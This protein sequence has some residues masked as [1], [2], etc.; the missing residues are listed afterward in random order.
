MLE[1]MIPL[2]QHG[3]T[4]TRHSVLFA[5]SNLTHHGG[6]EARRSI[7]M[8]TTP[9]IVELLAAPDC[10]T[11]IAE[12]GL[13]VL[14]HSLSSTVSEEI[15]DYT[16]GD[17]IH[18]PT[19]LRNI[20]AEGLL[21]AIGLIIRRPDVDVEAISH[22]LD[23]LRS[24]A[25]VYRNPMLATNTH[26]PLIAALASP[27]IHVRLEG[28]SG[29]LRLGG[30]AV[31][32]ESRLLN[33]MQVAQIAENPEKYFNPTLMKALR[34]Q[35]GGW[36]GGMIMEIAESAG[37]LDVEIQQLG[38][39]GDYAKLGRAL[40]KRILEH[41]YSLGHGVIMGPGGIEE[42]FDE[43]FQRAGDALRIT[44]NP[45]DAYFPAL[46]A[47]KTAM[48]HGDRDTIC[49][50]SAQAIRQFPDVAFFYYTQSIWTSDART[51]LR[52]AKKGLACS[53][54]TDYVKRGL[55]FRSAEAAYEMTM[56][57]PLE[58]AAPGSPAWR[59]AVAILHC[60]Q[61]DSKAYIEMT[62]M[63]Q[64]NM[65]TMLYTY[66]GISFILEGDAIYKNLDMIRV[67]LSELYVG[68]SAQLA[69]VVSA[70]YRKTVIG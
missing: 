37:A 41:E 64:R 32:K 3:P 33:P 31:E 66:L 24:L 5:L 17:V 59:E 18:I 35:Y 20:N 47:V 51:G 43:T 26:R 4:E 1:R 69:V 52:L 42:G 61:E 25:F 28:F 21:S 67:S 45:E 29:I 40:C 68:R 38:R 9:T 63:D 39:D 10:P 22:G 57:G 56:A 62:P 14:S 16:I 65:K 2:L 34:N 48:G 8:L 19:V 11:G 53:D 23:L 58:M 27:N 44:E 49:A 15:G 46:L 60:G 13:A 7:A 6:S 50:L 12:L 30:S 36:E 70:V 54:M 55:L